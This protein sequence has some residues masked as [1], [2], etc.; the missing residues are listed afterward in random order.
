[1]NA[2]APKPA[3]VLI[4]GVSAEWLAMVADLLR[5]E[6]RA[7]RA[8]AGPWI[9]VQNITT[10]R[11]EA[12][13]LDSDTRGGMTFATISDR[14]DALRAIE[15]LVY[16]VLVLE[17]DAAPSAITPEEAARIDKL[18]RTLHAIATRG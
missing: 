10:G 12:L 6:G 14:D 4:G 18:G 13:A 17:A 15:S 2:S 9:E 8:G 11:F 16:P 3:R 7:F 1:M 5:K